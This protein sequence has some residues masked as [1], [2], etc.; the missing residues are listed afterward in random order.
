MSI[1]TFITVVVGQQ[2]V[3][4]SCITPIM[5]C[6]LPTDV[7]QRVASCIIKITDIISKLNEFVHIMSA[8]RTFLTSL[9]LVG[10]VSVGYGMWATIVPGEEKKRELLKVS[11]A[12]V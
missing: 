5:H 8:M 12:L 9:A 4:K 7:V 11:L 10:V 2:L 3:K 1:Y 6:I